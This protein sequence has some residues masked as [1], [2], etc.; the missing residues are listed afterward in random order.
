MVTEWGMS[1]RLGP[2]RYA[3]NEQEVFLGHQLTQE[4]QVSEHT[5]RLIDEEVRR[6]VDEVE[7]RARQVL[8]EHRDDLHRLAQGLLEYESLT[9]EEVQTILRGES[10]Q[11]S[12]EPSGVD[13]RGKRP[14]VPRAGA[15]RDG[16]RGGD[17]EGLEPQP[18][19]S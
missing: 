6:V 14:S 3:E 2:L 7:Q 1:E 8:T 19:P 15:G 18:Q 4:Q 13:R 9:A 11:R 17:E 12:D 10:L 16:H 5:A